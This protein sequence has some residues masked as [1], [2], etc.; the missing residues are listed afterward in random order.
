MP[1]KKKEH[2][3]APAEAR[4]E[5]QP[6]AFVALDTETTGLDAD[7]DEIIEIGAVRWEDGAITGRYQTLVKAAKKVPPFV[8]ELTGIRQQDIDA[9]PPMESI[10]DSLTEFLGDAPLVMH[11]AGFDRSFLGSHLRLANPVWDSLTLARA[12]LPELRGHSLR[13]L[14]RH[15]DID[16]GRPHRAEDDAAATAR[17]F[18][19]LYRRLAALEPALIEQAR[20]LAQPD[21]RTLLARALAASHVAPPAA[22]GGA[23][24]APAAGPV[25]DDLSAV[26]G[27]GQALSRAMPA[28]FEDRD[29]QRRMA[30]AVHAALA[31]DHCLCVEAGTGTGKSLAYLAPAVIWSRASREKVVV[32]THTKTLQEQLFNKDVPLLRAAIGDFRAAVLKGRGNYLCRRRWLEAAT[33]PELFLAGGERDEALILAPWAWSTASGDIAE[34]RGFSTVRAGSLW[35]KVCSDHTACQAG[36]CREAG[37]CFLQQARRRAEDAD[38][39][40]VNH[41]LLFS[42]L[43][44]PSRVIPEYRRL[45]VDEAHN[46]E[47]VATDFL[48]HAMDRWAAQK[49]LA[50]LFTRHP[51]EGGLITAV[52]RW[53]RRAGLNRDAAGLIERSALA[54]AQLVVEASRQAERFF[55]RKWDLS[56]RRGRMEKRRFRAGDGFQQQVLEAANPLC[57]SL[58]Q[59]SRSL[60]LLGEWLDGAETSDPDERDNLRQELSSRSLEAR[61]MARTLGLLAAADEDGYIFWME[62]VERSQSIRLVAGPLEVGGVLHLRLYQKVKTA[63]FTSATLAVD[64]RFD[65]FK[66]RIGLSL[67]DGDL[68]QTM[69]LSSPFD[70]AAQAAIL[71]PQYLPSPKDRAFDEEFTEMLGRALSARKAGTL[72]LFTAFDQLFRS[73][74]KIRGLGGIN[75]AAQGMDGHPAQLA[76]RSLTEKLVIFGTSSFWEGVDLP[77][78]A[79][80]LLVI[81]RLPFAVPSDPLVS[82]RCEAIEEAG[83]SSFHQ[84]LLPEAVIRFR[85]GFGRLIRSRT[86]KGLVIVGDSRIVSQNYGQ[87][88]LRSLPK[89]PVVVCRDE[90]ELL[91]NIME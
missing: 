88:F 18:A 76:E 47:R 85:Q 78:A 6:L 69:V 16:P 74:H 31:G 22:A 81:A 28:G 35:S 13:G 86:D 63:V 25:V 87:V 55:N 77:G 33:H 23:V 84:Y 73:Y 9:A 66:S 41:S 62:P 3:I 21:Y 5:S 24:P 91:G 52:S 60:A 36:R 34:H 67:L 27:P 54:Q 43:I 37:R 64:G 50:T 30:A 48:G 40:I 61:G 53:L 83:G 10:L 71:V 15:F 80:E 49:F 38:V 90:E 75:L 11:N 44:A 20:H 79:C 4:E 45:V 17:V 8:T 7:S 32:S 29:E 14:C 26:F 2:S 72:V 57:E 46:V 42:D 68:V 70:Y 89:I 12:L 82:A 56:D 19:L 51:V 39:V 58:E 65:F 1:K 59:L